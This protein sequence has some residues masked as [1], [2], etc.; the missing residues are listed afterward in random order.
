[1]TSE[2]PDLANTSKKADISD[3]HSLFSESEG[4]YK[5][6]TGLKKSAIY[7]ASLQLL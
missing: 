4:K 3:R 6:L 2:V 7:L 5:S 1:M